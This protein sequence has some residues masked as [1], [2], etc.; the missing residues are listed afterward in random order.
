M[1][2]LLEEARYTQTI[3][4]QKAIKRC[5]ARMKF[6]K[7]LKRLRFAFK[8]A[9]R[10]YNNQLAKLCIKLYKKRKACE[11]LLNSIYMR[12]SSETVKH[13][14]VLTD[15]WIA[16]KRAEEERKRAEEEERKRAEEERK[17][18]EEE[19]RKRLEL[20]EGQRTSIED[21]ETRERDTM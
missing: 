3:K 13:W 14:K 16:Q 12:V 20:E 8:V 9:K 4:I 2:K 11:R 6:R 15:E 17:R 18:A 1:D 7:A 19:E 21:R 5:L 10:M